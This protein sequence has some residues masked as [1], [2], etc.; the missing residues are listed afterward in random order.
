MDTRATRL[1][2][3][4]HTLRHRAVIVWLLFLLACGVVIGRAHFSSD[5]SAF[6]PRAPSAG[7]RV[8]VDQLRDG[9]VS[10]LILIGIEG[11]DAPA[12]AALSQRMAATLRADP[13]FAAIQNGETADTSRDEAFVFA[14]RYLLSPAVTPQRF[15]AAGLHAALGDSLDLLTSSAGLAAKD[16]LPHDPTGE[17]AALASQFDGAAQP[18]LV[19]GVW[20]S[21]DGQRAVLVAQTAAA[22]SDIDA[23]AR[24]M[25]AVQRAF[26]AATHTVPGAT[27]ARLAMT[28]P[29]VFSVDTRDAIKHDVKRLSTASLVLIAALLLTLYRSARTLALGLLPVL[30]G[31]AA[32]IAAVAL[33][34]GT[35]HGLTLGFGTTL[36]GEAVD[37][38]IYL[39]V[40]S[41]R[42]AQTIRAARTP[43][44]AGAT[45][46]EDDA[47][48]AWTVAYW[49]TIRLGVLTSVCGF[50]SMLFSGFPGLVQLGLYSTAGLA[51]A[52]LVTRFVLPRLGAGRAA[53]RDVSRPGA[54][55][56]RAARVA[57][58]LRWPLALLV[59][60]AA[61]T[62]WLHRNGL[63]SHELAALS[64]VP[65]ASQALDARLRADVGAPDVRYLVVVPAASAQAAL[66]GAER[67]GAQLQPLVERGTLG[68]FESPA[69]FL[70]SDVTQRAR[71][72]S[73]PDPGVL[74]A[75][76]R[77]AVVD[78]PVTV[79]PELFAP[80]VAD[81][82]VARHQP[83]ITRADLR[84]TSM[85]LAVDALLREQAGQWSAMLALRAPD[86]ANADVNATA[87]AS[88]APDL[89][90]APVRAAVARA[91]VPGALFIDMKA[92]ADRL[93]TDYVREDVRLSLAGFAAI[94]VLLLIALRSA[95][96]AMRALAPL[97]AAVLTVAAGFALA[98]VALTILHLI[99]ML[100]IVAVGS[101]YAL[102]FCQRDSAHPIAPY[103]LVS[104][105]TANLAT[106]AGFGLL[107]LSHVPLL[108]TLGWTVAP[109]AMLALVFAAVLAPRPA[110]AGAA[111]PVT[112]AD[113]AHTERGHA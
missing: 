74:T 64:P 6:L 13:Q 8:L 47:M 103:T 63:W 55:L 78:Q 33:A 73:L 93:Y 89:D 11:A 52:A 1:A 40:Q 59:L 70:P 77:E 58:H 66:E 17:A 54:V 105:V 87:T 29:G 51:A 100:L 27:S 95:R 43:G 91:G 85:A 28:G 82:D 62:L 109:G 21:R 34:D 5:L 44:T 79:K 4:M 15:S 99:G 41:S 69:R 56:A 18:A 49:P 98:G 31:V 72:A 75:R 60:A 102:F 83:L 67:I 61:G 101:N 36:I 90:A 2:R 113:R 12:R 48:R 30:S 97:V 107:T 42:A 94:A 57:P 38:P 3:A 92:E 20:A 16:L 88:T 81:V 39:F 26:D 84:G 76:L 80:F 25:T 86:N 24:A 65:A 53:I 9:L 50:S 110:T 46:D 104:L 111:E 68:G 7:Q 71:E 14:H 10:R 96:R 106:V 19:D 32:G 23:Q 35:V 112:G 108:E 22:G 37:Y 45:R